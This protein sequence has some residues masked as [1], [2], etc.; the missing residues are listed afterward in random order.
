M[1]NFKNTAKNTVRSYTNQKHAVIVG[2]GGMEWE[3]L[4]MITVIL[5]KD[6]DEEFHDRADGKQKASNAAL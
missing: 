5:R 6:G 3:L 4:Q 1:L 2:N